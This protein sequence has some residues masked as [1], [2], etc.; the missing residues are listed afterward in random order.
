MKNYIKPSFM[1]VALEATASG[2]G[3]CTI[4][5]EEKEDL[6][7]TYGKDAFTSDGQCRVVV[8]GYCKYTSAEFANPVK[9]FGS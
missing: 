3:G 1:F 9:A 8:Q 6:I 4:S 5:K 2:T 7:L